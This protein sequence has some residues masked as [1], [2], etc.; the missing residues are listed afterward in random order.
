M[1]ADHCTS[2]STVTCGPI[3]RKLGAICADGSTAALACTPGT[4]FGAA[5]S[6]N[7][8]ATRAK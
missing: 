2:A 8:C 4:G 1:F 3:I 7:V 5:M 6:M